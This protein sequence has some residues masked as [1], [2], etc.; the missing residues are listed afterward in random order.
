MATATGYLNMAPT[1]RELGLIVIELNV[2][3]MIGRMAIRAIFTHLTLMTVI[4]LVA[5][6]ACACRLG[7]FFITSMTLGALCPHMAAGKRKVCKG[8]VKCIAVHAYNIKIT[9]FM[10]RMTTAA[11]G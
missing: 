8:V 6:N 3:P 2:L 7:I 11:G 1:K 5:G 4:L 10:V 9:T